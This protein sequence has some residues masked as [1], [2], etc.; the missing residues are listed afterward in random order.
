[1]LETSQIKLELIDKKNGESKNILKTENKGLIV[2][3]ETGKKPID[4]DNPLF[5]IAQF[6]TKLTK[7]ERKK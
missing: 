3:K 4:K 2:A 7:E 5:K 1:M 6:A